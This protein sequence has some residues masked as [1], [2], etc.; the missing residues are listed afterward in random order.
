M[1]SY[2]EYSFLFLPA[3]GIEPETSRWFHSKSLFDQMPYPR[4]HVSSWIYVG[5]P[6]RHETP[7]EGRRI[8]RPKHCEYNNKDEVNSP[9][10]LSGKNYQGSSKKFREM[11][12]YCICHFKCSFPWR[13]SLLGFKVLGEYMA[14]FLN[15]FCQDVKRLIRRLERITKKW[16]ESKFLSYLIK[17]V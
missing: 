2:R 1:L 3:A 14:L 11:V 16:S 6:A 8:Y 9:N 10:I 5:S 4:R 13:W 17:H 7:K 12:P 15:S